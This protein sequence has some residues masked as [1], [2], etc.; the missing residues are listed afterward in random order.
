[1]RLSVVLSMWRLYFSRM[2]Q[3]LFRS[4]I[5]YYVLTACTKVK[6]LLFFKPKSH[7]VI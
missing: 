4:Y 7:M 6:T 3:V 1:M 2:G 5:S